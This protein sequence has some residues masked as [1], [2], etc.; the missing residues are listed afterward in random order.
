ML[1]LVLNLAFNLRSEQQK[2]QIYGHDKLG[3]HSC[4]F[5]GFSCLFLTTRKLCVNVVIDVYPVLNG[6]F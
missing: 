1:I 6:L 3:G 2:R 4:G 5:N